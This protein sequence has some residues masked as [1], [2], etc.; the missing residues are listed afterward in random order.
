[1]PQKAAQ[2]RERS[3]LCGRLFEVLLVATL[4]L[5]IAPVALSQDPSVP[6]ATPSA[7]PT[8]A[9]PTRTPGPIES[10]RDIIS[11]TL[12]R[13][14]RPRD[15]DIRFDRI[16]IEEGLSQSTV[17]CILQDHK[18]YMWFGTEDGLNKYD[19]YNFTVYRHDP[20]DPNS[21]SNN[22]VRCILEDHTG[23]LWIGTRGGGLDRFDP[24]TEQFTHYNHDPRNPHTISGNNIQSIYEDGVGVLWI[25]TSEGGLDQF[26]P[27]NDQFLHYRHDPLDAHSLSDNSV[28]AI[29]QDRTGELWIGTYRGGLNLL[30]RA[31]QQFIHYQHHPEDPHSLSSNHVTAIHEDSEGLLW[32]G[33]GDGGINRLDP[34]TGRFIRYQN[35]PQNARSLSSNE[36]QAIYEDHAGVL[37]I[38][39]NGQGLDRY[40]PASDQF[41]HY[42]NDPLD[43]HSLSHNDVWSIYEDRGGVLWI[44]TF[45]G[46]VSKANPA[47]Q[48]FVHYHKDPSDPNT[49]SDNSVSSIWEDKS[50]YV[51]I[52]THSGGLNRFDPQSGQWTHYQHDPDDPYSLSS[53]HV[54]SIYEDRRGVLWLGTDGGLDRLDRENQRFFHY[55]HD[56][57]DSHSL[58]HNSVWPILED[59]SGT[60]WIGTLGGGLNKLNRASGQ[61]TRYQHDSSDPYSLS[62]ET[63]TSIY[64]SYDG[65]LWI[66]TM[67]GGLNRLDPDSGRFTHYRHDPMDAQSLSND[68]VFSITEDYRNRLYIGTWGGGLNRLDRRTGQF[69]HFREKDGLANDVVYGIL[70]DNTTYLWLSTNRGL[71][72]F[73][74]SSEKFRNY[75]VSDGL[76]D[77]TA[78][79]K[80]QYLYRLEGFDPDWVSAGTRRYQSYSNLRGGDY[81][82]RVKGSNSD[83]IWNREG[84]AIYITVTPPIWEERWFQGGLALLLL[85][86]VFAAYRLRLRNIEAHTRELESQVDERTYEIERRRLV[87]EGLR[88]ILVILN[89]NRSLRESLEHIA[90]QGALLTGAAQAVVFQREENGSVVTALGSQAHHA[91]GVTSRAVPP[92][93]AEWVAQAMQTQEPL[94]VPDTESYHA[95]NLQAP[96]AT[97]SRYRAVLGIPLSVGTEVY[98]GLVLFYLS[99][100]SFT[101][102]D[103][104]LGL[105]LVDHAA[106]AIANA[107]L[108]ERVEQMAAETERSRLARDLHDAVTQTLFSASLI[109]EV[110]P[111]T[112]ECDPEDGRE[113]LTELRQL[114]RGAMAEMRTLLLELRPAALAEATLGDLLRQL[115]EAVTGRTGTP[116]EVSL[117]GQCALPDDVQ[118]ALYR[119]AQEALNN[120]I[121]HAHASQVDIRLRCT[122]V[123]AGDG[124]RQ[125]HIVDMQIKDNGDGFDPSDTP[126]HHLGLRIIRER[127]QAIGARLEIDS[128][129]GQGTR[130]TVV[131][132]GTA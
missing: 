101:E 21:L 50:G 32:I 78:P 83:G 132:T 58:S 6:A 84:R 62:H 18:G 124:D 112:W 64:E 80:N 43:R 42:L 40:D 54:R 7:T 61:F 81:I 115:G 38:G 79:H 125:Q 128:R 33:T 29:L 72:R 2:Q 11:I 20:Q 60:L 45:G 75:D 99:K 17:G 59:T 13:D 34:E 16:S 56:P 15:N 106:L 94:I 4:C 86:S 48:K 113:L 100:R 102:E 92:G 107:Q 122:P 39:T 119:I 44:G 23:V 114:S 41:V 9:R 77:Y 111:S 67:G 121:K 96:P 37:W 89:S 24:E 69:T 70:E 85:A 109:A 130:V 110:L 76:L 65:V 22:Y 82:F 52:G 118:V 87:A 131:W 103:L 98:G 3:A 91:P 51:W 28:L 126:P 68:R 19:G 104:E 57:G 12:P 1:V 108:R 14:Q 63:V 95:S 26:N 71:S 97:M 117:D 55:R 129:L 120:V 116:V 35:D 105:T 53:N 66:G 127:A 90:S 88:E 10:D 25:G 8:P 123:Q 46:G 73:T 74:S 36:V 47:N 93:T 30:D 49:L 31:Q 27:E 5:G